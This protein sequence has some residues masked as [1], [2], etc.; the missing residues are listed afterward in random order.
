MLDSVCWFLTGSLLVIGNWVGIDSQAA[1]GAESAPAVTSEAE[2]VRQLEVAVA[3]GG[4]QAGLALLQKTL[5]SEPRN[6]P[7]RFFLATAYD[8]LGDPEGCIRTAREGIAMSCV[9]S[10]EMAHFPHSIWPT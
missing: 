3:G 8:A 5:E 6:L 1:R 2:I 10:S 4:S 7:A 9:P